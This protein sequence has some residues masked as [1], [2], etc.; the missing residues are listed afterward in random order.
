VLNDSGIEWKTVSRNLAGRSKLNYTYDV[1]IPSSA[2]GVYENTV[3][4]SYATGDVSTTYS[5]NVYCNPNT[6][7]LDGNNIDKGLYFVLCGIVFLGGSMLLG[8]YYKTR[9]KILINGKQTR[10]IK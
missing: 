1:K 8:G 7:L 2:F 9:D 4:V 3:K 6:A 10:V 5:M